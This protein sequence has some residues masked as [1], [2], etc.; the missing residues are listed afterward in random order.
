[1]VQEDTVGAVTHPSGKKVR[2]GLPAEEAGV[3]TTPISEVGAFSSQSW[4]D[5]SEVLDQS[6]RKAEAQLEQV[7][8]LQSAGSFGAMYTRSQSAKSPKLTRLQRDLAQIVDSLPAQDDMDLD[9]HEVQEPLSAE[10]R[11]KMEEDPVDKP[12]EDV[13]RDRL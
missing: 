3:E 8:A 12:L 11:S 7:G 5:T 4:R 13:K 10:E 9:E 2:C 6:V 1:M